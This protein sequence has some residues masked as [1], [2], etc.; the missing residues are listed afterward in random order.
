MSAHDRVRWD[1]IY[2]QLNNRPFPAP[3]A[4]LLDYTPPVPEQRE[5][6][7]L[8]LACGYGQN[9][10]WLAEQGYVTDLMDVSRVALTRARAEMAARNLR[11]INVL[12]IDLDDLDLEEETYHLVCIFRYLKRDFMRKLRGAVIPG[13]RVIYETYN[14]RYLQIV[15]EFN[16]KFLLALNELPSLFE[17]WKIIHFEDIEHLSQIVAIKPG[18]M[19]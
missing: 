16:Q 14:R 8:D 15:P 1:T 11:N 17:G 13:G 3:D 19:F 2:T 12:Q 6:R 10:L 18:E 9:G 5:R 4:L 7:A